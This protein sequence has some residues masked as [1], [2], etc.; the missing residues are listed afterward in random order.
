M[1]SK[2]PAVKGF[3]D[4][5]PPEARA[6]RRLLRAAESVLERY[7]YAEI[8]LP[9]LERGELF[10]RSVGATTDIVE[11]EMYA[12]EDRDG[13][14]VALRPEGTASVVR[15]Y[16]ESGMSRSQPVARL[17]YHGAM[18][19][20]ER[21][22]KGRFRQ[23]SQIG[24]ELLGRD[25]AQSDAE[26]LCLV[27]DICRE[28]RLGNV[29]IEI[30]SLGDRACRPAYRSALAAFGAQ[31]VDRLCV[32]CRA[33]L[34]RNPLRL[35]DCKNEACRAVMADAPRMR[36]FLC[37]PC[38]S[39]HERVLA[40][41]SAAGVELEENPSMVR[42]LDYYCRTAF[43]VTAGGLGSQAAVGGGGR[44]DGLVAE[45]GGS[46]VPGVGFAF[47]LE[48]MWM[49]AAAAAEKR[50]EAATP[51]GWREE[52]IDAP[53]P[54]LFVA[55]VSAPAESAAIALARRLRGTGRVVELGPSD[56]KLK[57]QLKL[58]DR[59]GARWVVIVGDREVETGRA[60]VR[61]LRARTDYP[62]C[63]D[64]SASGDDVVRS[65]ERMVKREA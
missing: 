33:R 26:T 5:L 20:R 24:A 39:H 4:V 30:N 65:I 12:F 10:A 54:E 58:A 46:D 29:T 43:E 21:P 59:A 61:D 19:R 14:L 41:A 8:E 22:Q 48:R 1:S 18:F 45:L 42:G 3:R 63:V 9:L 60:S 62:E 57:A 55:P 25:D 32:D 37:D 13:T 64:L 31:H 7:G 11:K 15:A 38:R 23:F 28:A 27:A 35:L 47:G 17:Y 50:R 36:D 2:I 44:Y 52:G 53:R 56:R 6:R 34:E 16:L 49:A 51:E 40:L